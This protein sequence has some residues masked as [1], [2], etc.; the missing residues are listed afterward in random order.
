MLRLPLSTVYVVCMKQ[1]KR[2]QT[3]L[4]ENSIKSSEKTHLW[5][6]TLQPSHAC[7]P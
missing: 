4:N 6:L 1:F 7:T 5:Q 3:Y 2:L